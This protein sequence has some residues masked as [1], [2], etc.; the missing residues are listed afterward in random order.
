MQT[1][2]GNWRLGE[3]IGE[4]GMGTVYLAH[5]K[6]L[7]APAAFKILAPALTRDPRFRERFMR[8][9]KAHAQMRHSGIA[10]VI[11]FIEQDDQ[12]NLVMEYLP[13]GTLA[14]MLEREK[15]PRP[16]KQ[17]LS[18]ARRAL[19]ALD[20]AHQRGVIHRDV[21]PSNI[22]FDEHGQAK[23]VDFGIAL[24][25]DGRRLTTTGALGTPHYMSPEQIRQPL[26]VDHRTDVY[27]MGVVLYEML[28]GRAPFDGESDFDIRYA[29]VNEPPKP[30]RPLNPEVNEELESIVFRAMAKKADDRYAGC[31]EM[32]RELAALEQNGTEPISS[33]PGGDGQALE[34]IRSEAR[35]WKRGAFFA[36]VL[37]F[38]GLAATATMMNQK[39]RQKTDW[40]L[41]A[42]NE[43][44]S[45]KDSLQ[46]AQNELKSTRATLTTLSELSAAK[47]WP[48]AVWDDF[49]YTGYAW[50][51]G[52]T[53]PDE[54]GT[55]TR[56]IDNGVYHWALSSRKPV[57]W[58]APRLGTD[59]SGA[60]AYLSVDATQTSG[61][62][63]GTYALVFRVSG[64]DYYKFEISD[65]TYTLSLHKDGTWKSLLEPQSSPAIHPHQ[66]NRLAVLIQGS[67]FRL[68]VNDQLVGEI[69]DDTLKTGVC[70][71]AAGTTKENDSVAFDFKHFELR[72]RPS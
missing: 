53:G 42:T 44:S 46:T 52:T 4:G 28:A 33:L 20:Y 72:K 61:G 65:D 51:T 32:E 29:Q 62:N 66:A 67:R 27:A 54:F 49:S 34:T 57:F 12:L 30:L 15:R 58:W 14:E 11:D 18:W 2:I 69:T 43:L 9:A 47:S 55:G 31:G 17:A 41:T 3:K 13:G 24:V 71:L 22:L 38:V 5:H 40:W 7:G 19:T 48:L 8:E 68:F 39:I 26:E 10:Q 36:I 21:K 25:L 63:N 59:L 37:G 50:N 6:I 1:E 16:L 60:E 64:Q 45:T 23:L 35:R 70:G 56:G